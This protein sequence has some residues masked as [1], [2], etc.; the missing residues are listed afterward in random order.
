MDLY[1]NYIFRFFFFSTG[2]FWCGLTCQWLSGSA[3]SLSC[4]FLKW[5]RCSSDLGVK[6]KQYVSEFRLWKV[7]TERKAHTHST[8]RGL[9]RNNSNKWMKLC[10]ENVIIF[11]VC[12]S[13]RVTYIFFLSAILNRGRRYSSNVFYVNI[14]RT[15]VVSD[16]S[17]R[18]F[19]SGRRHY[20]YW[21]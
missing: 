8:R 14:V 16:F 6:W 19:F 20:K 15:H 4:A 3:S 11:Y 7:S 10:C 13:M 9:D 21:N 2:L 1:D 18:D 5:R 17:E 12:V